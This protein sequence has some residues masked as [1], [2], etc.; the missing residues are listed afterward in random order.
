MTQDDTFKQDYENADLKPTIL[1]EDLF[2]RQPIC[3]EIIAQ[4]F[5]Y[6][7]VCKPSSHKILSEYITGID[8]NKHKIKTKKGSIEF[9]FIEKVPLKDGEDSLHVNWFEVIEKN[10]S[11][12]VVYHNNFITT[13]AITKEKLL[14]LSRAGK[15]RWRIENENNNTLKTKGYC[16]E[17]NYGHSSKHLS[18]VF[19]TLACIAFLFHIVMDLLCASYQ[20]AKEALG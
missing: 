20:R 11:S 16:F 5:Y 6:I 3:K 17:H 8:L 1:G 18:Y 15:A 19:A 2:S 13:H 14:D 9:R 10:K 12:K 4:G 7:L